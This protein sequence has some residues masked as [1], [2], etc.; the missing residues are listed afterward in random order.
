LKEIGSIVGVLDFSV[1]LD[2]W[3]AGVEACGVEPPE[4]LLPALPVLPLLLELHPAIVR[5]LATRS[6]GSTVYVRLA[7]CLRM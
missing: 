6:A 5:T 7:V 3:E 4:P 2:G 1:P